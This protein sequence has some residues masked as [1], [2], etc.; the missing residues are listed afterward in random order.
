[1]SEFLN[2]LASYPSDRPALIFPRLEQHYS[3]G[4]IRDLVELQHHRFRQAGLKSKQIALLCYPNCIEAI[5]AF[6]ACLELGAV[7]TLVPYLRKPEERTHRS[8]QIAQL[9]GARL[10]MSPD[11]L[12]CF[13]DGLDCDAYYIQFGS[14][15][16]GHPK[17]AR[18]SEA[19]LLSNIH[20]VTQVFSLTGR[21]VAV[22]WLPFFH[23]MGLFGQLL[24]PLFLG[25]LTVVQ[26]PQQ[27]V[28][29]PG[30]LLLDIQSYRGS[31]SW[32]PSTGFSHLLRAATR[33]PSNLDLSSLR[34]C[35]CGGELVNPEVLKAFCQWLAPY[36]FD[37]NAITI[38]YGMAENVCCVSLQRGLV[39][40]EDGTVSCGTPLPGTDLRVN[41]RGEIEVSGPSLFSGYCGQ[42]GPFWHPTGDFGYLQD[43]RIYV[44]ERIS[45][46][47]ALE[48]RKIFPADLEQ[49]ALRTLGSTVGRAVAFGCNL[50]SGRTKV[51]V[52]LEAPANQL[53]SV[54]EMEIAAALRAKTQTPLGDVRL[55]KRGWISVTTSGKVA[56]AANREKYLADFGSQNEIGE[57]PQ[58][59]LELQIAELFGR[60]LFDG[61]STQPIGR[62]QS[63]FSLGGSSL[64]AAHLG[65]LLQ[66]TFA[67]PITLQQL[68]DAPTIAGLAQL[69]VTL[70][71]HRQ[72]LWVR[73]R[74]SRT[75]QS[76]ATP[77]ARPQPWF[78]VPGMG[79][80]ALW[81][82]PLLAAVPPNQAVYA[83]QDPRLN[84]IE[85]DFS[86][87]E[88]T[89]AALIVQ[90]QTIQS[91][92]PYC[93]IGNCYGAWIVYEM[94]QQL[95]AQ[96]QTIE[97]LILL[98]SDP[99][100][101]SPPPPETILEKLKSRLRAILVKCWEW[102]KR[103]WEYRGRPDKLHRDR[104]WAAQFQAAKAY[105]IQP[106]PADAPA[107]VN[108]LGNH[109]LQP[110]HSM[111]LPF[112]WNRL[113]G[114]RLRFELI[115]YPAAGPWIES[116]QVSGRL[117]KLT[118]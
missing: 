9:L 102:L 92:G 109:P 56:R 117:L 75:A 118:T 24:L 20:Q 44:Q 96:G 100:Y 104:T 66:S 63:F 97:R 4:Q 71:W 88:Q 115:E 38:G 61:Q 7:P 90:L 105:N 22:G 94:T 65:T 87:V 41:D 19:A 73:L 60:A 26:D 31:W 83:F 32:M 58:G 95:L 64:Q 10:L 85:T 36:G 47:I 2:R 48:G 27:W 59:T 99:F 55:V 74:Q 93:L 35:G 81:A 25:M 16:T 23:D 40:S 12:E 29:A 89:A 46:I 113:V 45:D 78:I 107:E 33:I 34:I 80:S 86:S 69:V 82:R 14:G 108:L 49:L 116:P 91:Q 5:I 6:L 79:Q 21:D 62:N 37:A 3:H 13:E 112:D 39:C 42:A 68:W 111:R 11:G 84:A 53:G 57:L 8:R 1:V 114:D 50:G 98:D 67:S 18:I 43:G 76:G 17:A 110:T 72:P 77:K 52:I 54:R 30:S 70:D 28:R 15:T 51:V 101:Q 106:L 103:K